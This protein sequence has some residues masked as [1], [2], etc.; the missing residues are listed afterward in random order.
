MSFALEPIWDWQW[1]ILMAVAIFALVLLTYPRSVRHQPPAT[2]KLLIGLR[3][4]AALLLLIAML[5]PVLQWSKTDSQKAVLFVVTDVSRSMT[6]PDGPASTT[7][8]QALLQLLIE[9][10]KKLSKLGDK[11]DIQYFDF[12]T[13]L[14]AV[15]TPSVLA[16]GKETAIGA[17]L[18]ELLKA[19]QSKK[20]AGIV[21]MSDGAERIAG[22]RKIDPRLMAQR[23]A[24][25]QLPIY[26]IGFGGEGVTGNHVDLAI[27]SMLVDPLVFEKKRVPI[28]LK[29]RATGAAGRELTVKIWLE[30][31]TGKKVGEVGEM[32]PVFATND[33]VPLK[34]F[35]PQK[36][37][38]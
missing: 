3:L 4:L 2:R 36:M 10:E 8:R 24:E 25:L 14:T 29:L 37:M 21:L 31:R 32:N 11:I 28:S 5:R 34:K 1:V 9:N 27:E 22:S 13:K 15:E 35:A 16:E 19:S 23:F 33:T 12:A 38:N 30:D 18:E 7:R 17:V 26:T 20:V 6:T